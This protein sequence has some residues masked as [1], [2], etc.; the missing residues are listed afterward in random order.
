VPGS[1]QHKM[2]TFLV[3]GAAR[4]GTTAL[5]NYLRQHPMIYMS[6]IKEPNFFAFEG[7]RPEYT[8]PGAH[9]VNN[10]ITDLSAYQALF[11]KATDEAVLGEASPLYLYLNKTAERLHHHLPGVSLVAVLRNPIAQAYSHFLYAHRETIEPLTDFT[12]ALKAEEERAQAGWMP[13]FQYSLF[14]H[15]H[16]QLTR[17]LSVF[18]A[19]RIKVFLYE[20]FLESPQGVLSQLFDFLGVDDAFVPDVS[21]RP[22]T[23]GIPKSGLFQ[24][25]MMKPYGLTKAIGM[26][27][28]LK[29]RSRVKDALSDLN[30]TQ[31]PIPDEARDILMTRLRD[32]ML[33]L[34][35]LLDRDLSAWLA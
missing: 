19:N 24:S 22:N 4:S 12:S 34:Q 13:M 7:Q 30:L 14:P 33:R 9:F 10:S 15:Y 32:D 31:P 21:H 8:G 28:P 18:P 20:D 23:G 1:T 26:L 27:L 17:Y 16:D 29:L 5:Y 35:D 25:I 2:P 3:I 6:P 11:E